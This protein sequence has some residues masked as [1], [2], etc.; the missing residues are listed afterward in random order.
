MRFFLAVLFLFSTAC[1]ELFRQAPPAAVGSG[2]STGLNKAHTQQ[3]P[4]PSQTDPE[5]TKTKSETIEPLTDFGGVRCH[6]SQV[7]QFNNHVRNFLSTSNDPNQAKYFVD[8]SGNQNWKG[9]FFIRGKVE[10]S[11]QKFDPQSQSQDLTAAQ[12]S[13]LEIHIVDING[14]NVSPT[15]R[16]NIDSYAS[17]F[18]GQNVSLV[19]QD[20]KGRVLLNGSVEKDSQNRLIFSGSFEFENSITWTGSNQGLS[21]TL[22][23]FKI[24]ACQFF[25]CASSTALPDSL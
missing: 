2:I 17:A 7:T 15:I 3:Q 9:G 19:F 14:R 24:A 1:S 6:S 22:G 21:G 16:M 13:Y 23:F 10:F 18:E 20:S 11:G 12:N 5:K 4:P 8:C 25:D